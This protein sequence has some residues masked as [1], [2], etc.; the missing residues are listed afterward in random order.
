MAVSNPDKILYRAAGFTKGQVIDYYIRVSE[1]LL[2]HFQN[3]PVTLKRFPDGIHGQV[4]YEKD[5]PG[6][7]P[8][9]VKTFPVPRK[10]GGPDIQY[11]LINDLATLVWC[12][13]IASL[14]LHPFLHCVPELE[15]PRSVVFDLDPGEG[16]NVLDCARVAFLVKEVLDNL[17][18][19]SFPKVS[20]SKGLQLYVPLNTP[21][22]YEV[23][24]PF[25]RALAELLSQEYP[26]LIVAEMAK[27]ERGHKVFI[28]WSQNSDFK[29]TV[30]VYSLRAKLEQPFV[31][32]PVTWDELSAAMKSKDTKA[33]YWAPDAALHR[34]GT[35]GDL[36]KAVLEMQQSLPES[37]S[38]IVSKVPKSLRT[39][40]VKR[41]F[42]KTAEPRAAAPPPSAQGARKRFV[43]QK[44]AASHLH[45]DF[46]LEMHGVLKSWAV[47]KGVPYESDEKRLAMATEDHPLEYL[48]FE[49]TIPEGQYGGGTV[50]VWDIGSYELIE[51]NYYKGVLKI[52]LKG[53]KLKGEWQ[54][55]KNRSKQDN[56]WF[57]LKSEPAMKPLTAKK[58][59]ISA[60][61]GR[62]IEQIAQDR[63]AQW[64]SNR[65]D[66][67]GLQ[68]DHLPQSAMKFVEPM[69]CKLVSAL[70][71]GPDW[72]Y[73]VK[74]D[75]YRA[76]I[77]KASGTV[78]V[79]SRRNHSMNSD[80]PELANDAGKLEDGVIL[81]GEI[82]VVDDRGRPQFNLLQ[83][84][85]PGEGILQYYAF[86]VLAYRQ[87]DTRGLP[88]SQRRQ[89][90]D[91][92]LASGKD[93]I[94]KQSVPLDAEPDQLIE[95]VRRHGLEGIVAKKAESRY[96]SGERSGN[97]IKY[98][99]NQGQE[100]VVG[101]YRPGGKNH[102]ENLA[103]GYYD[104]DRLIF[105]A[106]LKNG[107]TPDVKNY[108]Y[109][110][111]QKLVTDKCPFANLPEPKN[112]RRGE[113]LT[114]EAMKNY[115]WIRPKLVVQV[116]FT[117]WTTSNHLRHSKLVGI[118]KDKDPRSVT[119]EV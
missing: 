40:Q 53:K 104:G 15:T 102:F 109:K 48:E 84:Y 91:A 30:G 33:L 108:I 38:A 97:W 82:V 25:A 93:S 119:K 60:V 115:R 9:W 37:V 105:I 86:D 92:I 47:P 70:P 18:L 71:K 95:A 65:T 45:Y 79:L 78:S 75:G 74:L 67:P 4:F 44:H 101:G 111:L 28:D 50:M 42:A 99:T 12:A 76:E 117:D 24:R 81:D 94:L 54:L 20:G 6:Y 21:V 89:I 49:G 26:D 22:T 14:E 39:Y 57:L 7:K 88:L 36:F 3:R 58:E 73:E 118:R 63:D 59:N 107:F 17:K 66:V 46:R 96:E 68:L 29:T 52:F 85:K 32:L 16:R 61:T 2:P 87:K 83:H 69:L 1:Y 51:G 106:K 55:V 34:L 100:L 80:Y 10:A 31:S 72:Q 116:E 56:R 43:I 113:A 19:S 11:I 112:A 23:T 114:A 8:E 62:T 27:S 13:N 41:N 35:V 110:R 5:A 64:H 90:L 98:K 77:V 103:V